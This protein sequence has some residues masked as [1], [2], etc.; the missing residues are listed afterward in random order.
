M[1][2]LRVAVVGCGIGGPA[3][4][5]FFSPAGNSVVVFERAEQLGPKGAGILIAPTG[6]FVLEKLGLLK[7]ALDHGSRVQRLEGHTMRGR[8]IMDIR[9]RLLSTGLFGLGIHRGALFS[10]LHEAMK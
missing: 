2:G 3:A 8:K 9:Y 6:Q 5:L 10:I 1:A 7:E 4:A